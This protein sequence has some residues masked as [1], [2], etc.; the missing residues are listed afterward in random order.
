MKQVLVILL[1]FAFSIP[2]KALSMESERD[3]KMLKFM[4]DFRVKSWGKRE[5]QYALITCLIPR[6]QKVPGKMCKVRVEH[7]DD[8]GYTNIY[9][10]YEENALAIAALL[11]EFNI[12][13]WGKK[14][15]QDAEIECAFNR[16]SK[17]P[18]KICKVIDDSLIW[19]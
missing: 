13:S 17:L 18:V 8:P 10:I 5:K 19:P 1:V 9:R 15:R 4:K 12:E 7:P 6:K 2:T 3:L 11:K 16:K 14:D